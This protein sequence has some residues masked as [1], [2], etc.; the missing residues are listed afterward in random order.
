MA[1]PRIVFF[2]LETLPNMREAMKIFPRLG[3]YPGLTLKATVNSVICFGYSVL[4]ET[5]THCLNAWDF[6]AWKSDINDDRAL[7]SAAYEVL[8]GADAVVTHNGKRFDWKFL[9]TRLM[10]HGLPP[11]PKT[12]HIDTCAEAKKNLYLFN[13]ALNTVALALTDKEKLEHEGW[14]LWVRVSERDPEALSLM[15]E[16]CK[17][18]VN[19]LRDV[20]R[21]L[22]PFL[23]QLPNHNVFVIG[24]SANLCPVCGSTR[25]YSNGIRATKLVSYRRYTCQDCGASSRTNLSDQMPRAL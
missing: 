19:V 14:N 12:P 11:L 3:N 25:L 9:Q 4:G 5:D 6:P 23:T 16:Y 24:G 13:N 15:S 18:D 22:R 10:V 17:Q 1:D 7:V 8:K 20:F 21:R 2:D